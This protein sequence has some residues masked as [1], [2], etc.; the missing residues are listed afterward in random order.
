M[1]DRFDPFD[2]VLSEA[3]IHGRVAR[4]AAGDRP[5][6]LLLHGHPQTHV[7][8]HAIADRLA[9]D[10]TVVA[11]DLRGYGHSSRPASDAR[12]L[13][14]SKRAMGR[15]QV[16]LMAQFGFDRFAVCAHDRGARVA[17]RMMVDHPEVVTRGMFLDIAPTLDM[18]SG[19]TRAFAEAYFHWFLLIQPAPLPE[20][21][22]SAD[23]GGY[24]RGVMGARYAGLAPFAPEAL[25]AYE[26]ALEQDGAAH[27]ICEDYRASAT[28]DLDDERDDR[29]RGL[30]ITA[31]LRVLWGRHG[32]VGRL[33]D[34]LA[35]WQPLAADVSGR[36]LDCGHYIA[37]E[38]PG[39]LYQEIREHFGPG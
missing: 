13:P 3:T 32:V 19:T 35:L 14:Y 16:E 8:W 27:A 2:V 6:L 26:E 12:H 30:L 9:E 37:E 15:D 17:H 4:A 5:P 24:L 25:A 29:D 34:P 23:P 10:F 38:L 21:M 28:M 36:A 1:F 33:F 20:T 18:Y 22:I 31:P 39:P 7:M 11:A